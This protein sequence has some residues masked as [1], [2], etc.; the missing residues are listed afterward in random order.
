MK[1]NMVLFF[2]KFSIYTFLFLCVACNITVIP[3]S[4]K[5][6]DNSADVAN[7]SKPYT[8]L[9]TS[10]EIYIKLNDE[11]VSLKEK[12]TVLLDAIKNSSISYMFGDILKDN[13]DENK[14]FYQEQVLD[15]IFKQKEDSLWEIFFKERFFK[16]EAG[17]IPSANLLSFY[18]NWLIK[19]QNV[20]SLKFLLSTE[21]GKPYKERIFKTLANNI[22]KLALQE[23]SKEEQNTYIESAVKFLKTK[24]PEVQW[25]DV[26]QQYAVYLDK[27]SQEYIL[28]QNYL[29]NN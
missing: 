13:N 17:G 10:Q 6:S 29:L 24:Y 18:C 1:C 7:D 3:S 16:N 20:D 14:K 21:A 23:K 22:V 11:D 8:G 9:N 25:N 15:I 19:K 2:Y 4:L 27:A 28:I 26:I 12:E 5:K